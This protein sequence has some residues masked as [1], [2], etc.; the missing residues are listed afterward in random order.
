M[1]SLRVASAVLLISSAAAVADDAR[2][3]PRAVSCLGVG[4][5][6]G[7]IYDYQAGTL[8]P[9]LDSIL[10]EMARL[11]REK[12][13]GRTVIIQAHAYE[14]PTPQLNEELSELRALTLQHELARRGIPASNLI[15]IGRG[16][17]LPLAPA[18][19]ADAMQINRRV[20]FRVTD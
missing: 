5:L 20:S 1:R 15:A 16:D 6:R 10:D 8:Q 13:P 14:M 2:D 17:T 9:G 18:G 3:D 19:D 7:A 4:R 12:C 11:Y